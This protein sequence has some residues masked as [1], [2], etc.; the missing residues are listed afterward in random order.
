VSGAA[1]R[2][3][4]AAVDLAG[5]ANL[6]VAI[7]L[8]NGGNL[9]LDDVAKDAGISLSLFLSP[10]F[11]IAIACLGLAFFFYVRSL[12]KLPLA[13]AYPV[14]VGVSMIVVAVA[15]HFWG[16]TALG[17]VQLAGVLTLFLGV[18]LISTAGSRR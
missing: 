3:L 6:L 17:V 7:G 10:E 15:N 12:A 2:R 9:L 8:L 11:V 4:S 18:V 14:M 1:E 16:Q 5:W 13:V